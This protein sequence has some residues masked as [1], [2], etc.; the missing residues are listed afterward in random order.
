MGIKTRQKIN[1]ETEDLNNKINQQDLT[2]ITLY[3]RTKHT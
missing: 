3:P 1:E 2:L